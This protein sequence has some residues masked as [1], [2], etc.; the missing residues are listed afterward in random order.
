MLDFICIGPVELRGKQSKQKLQNQK[1]NLVQN[2]IR[3]HNPKI[4]RP[5]LHQLDQPGLV[6]NLLR[7][8][9]VEHGGIKV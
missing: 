4:M 1:P 8:Y 9:N 6:E 7:K 5:I 3:T 2:W